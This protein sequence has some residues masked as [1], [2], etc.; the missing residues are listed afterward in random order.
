MVA[1]TKKKTKEQ[2]S[3]E[4]QNL[5][6]QLQG[7]LEANMQVHYFI[8]NHLLRKDNEHLQAEARQIS[9]LM[10]SRANAIKAQM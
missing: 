3:L 1:K 10:V 8:Q 6:S 5:T 2:E 7:Q 4:H 9:E